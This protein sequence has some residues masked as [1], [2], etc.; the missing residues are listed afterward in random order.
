MDTSKD[1]NNTQEVKIY[2]NKCKQLLGEIIKHHKEE[3]G[4]PESWEK[5][6]KED[7]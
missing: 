1:S 6:G 5:V 7:D 4:F 3:H 2:C